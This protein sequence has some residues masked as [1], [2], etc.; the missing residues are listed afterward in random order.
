[1][2]SVPRTPCVKL[3]LDDFGTL[4]KV[5]E[6][7]KRHI[8]SIVSF[9]VLPVSALLRG[10]RCGRP[11]K[12]GSAYAWED[13]NATDIKKYEGTRPCL[14]NHHQNT[15]KSESRMELPFAK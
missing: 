13:Q 2:T 7:R 15:K 5:R 12:V 11:E 1:M 6:S 10:G 8:F 14:E 3:F 4:E 9:F